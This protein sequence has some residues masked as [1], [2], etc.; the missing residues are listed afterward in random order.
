MPGLS[1][2]YDRDAIPVQRE[3]LLAACDETIVQN[4]Y[5]REIIRETKSLLMV[6]VGYN[7][8]PYLT[9][10]DE[11]FFVY[12][13]GRVYDRDVNIIQQE[14]PPLL[15]HL[16]DGGGSQRLTDYLMQLDADAIVVAH[17]TH[18]DRVLVFNDSL[19]RLPLYHWQQKDRLVISRDLRLIT[20]LMQ[21][22]GKGVAFDRYAM[23]EFLIFGFALGG[24][25][26]IQGPRRIVP[27]S[28]LILG[29]GQ[30]QVDTHLVWNFDEKAH[31]HRPMKENVEA[32]VPLF[33]DAARR[34]YIPAVTNLVSMSGG[35]DSRMVGAALMNNN[36]PACS[37]TF[38]DHA[39]NVQLDAD[40]ARALSQQLAIP[41]ELIHLPAITG[42][43]IAD[44]VRI[45]TGICSANLALILPFFQAL[46]DKYGMDMIY[47]TGD[48]G[49]RTLKDLR[50]QTTPHNADD[51]AHF[52]LA[53][54][55][56]FPLALAAQLV[57]INPS[58]LYES[59]RTHLLG[60]PE[61][62][63]RQKYT[64]F[65]MY[66]RA[67]NWL[68]ENEDRNRLHFWSTTPYYGI[69]FWIYAMNVP[70]GQKAYRA[71]HRELIRLMNPGLATITDA[72]LG[73]SPTSVKYLFMFALK[74]RMIGVFSRSQT[75]ARRGKR[76]IGRVSTYP[77]HH[78]I[79][80][81]VRDQFTNS[82]S[83][84]NYLNR[85]VAL[86]YLS[87][88][89]QTTRAQMQLLLSTAAVIE[90]FHEKN[91]TLLQPAYVDTALL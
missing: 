11:R 51:L 67:F 37:A 7:A 2:I 70:D 17:D 74:Q 5:R 85:E 33:Y 42:R 14:L 60:Y 86:A 48:G 89:E 28:L 21:A 30:F 22:V 25:T 53:R 23:A 57:G 50:S 19:G 83:V 49:D 75:L 63:W 64:H 61:K 41:W 6:E 59:I 44:L 47:W 66:E 87:N 79:F 29:D 9:F 69:E 81:A 38:L 20:N 8:Y 10:E 55:H 43:H 52:T 80:S 46:Q 56:Q 54:N 15:A 4:N 77:T 45:K 62:Q 88:V 12:V 78:P 39:G 91:K 34:R 35:F 90:E 13:E 71:L 24:K 32:L 36:L 72:N 68:F 27:G 58:D 26:V 73:L 18:S 1:L 84:S 16:A 76:L 31:R 82:P 65:W 3:T 40:I